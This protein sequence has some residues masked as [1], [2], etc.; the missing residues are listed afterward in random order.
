M[1]FVQDAQF[2][3]CSFLESELFTVVL[4]GTSLYLK[5]PSEKAKKLEA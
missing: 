4:S 2:W 1:C 3:R 5:V